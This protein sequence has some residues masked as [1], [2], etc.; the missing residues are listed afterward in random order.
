M[1]YPRYREKSQRD[2]LLLYTRII[3]LLTLISYSSEQ[4]PF[5]TFPTYGIREKKKRIKTLRQSIRVKP[6]NT[7]N[8]R[9]QAV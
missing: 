1:R 7:L 4:I 3:S 5:A 2:T 9:N 8:Y 6:I